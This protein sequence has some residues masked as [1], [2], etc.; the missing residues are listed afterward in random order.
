MRNKAVRTLTLIGFLVSSAFLAAGS[1]AAQ[2]AEGPSTQAFFRLIGTVG[3]KGF[4][5]AVIVDGTGAQTF[6]RLHDTAPDGS[7]IVAVE[8]DRIS[9][10]RPDGTRYE[11]FIIHDMMAS[12][13]SR[14]A[15]DTAS[16]ATGATDIR[17]TSPDMQRFAPRPG[18][19][20]P[21]AAAR[22]EAMERHRNKAGRN[23]GDQGAGT[24]QQNTAPQSGRNAV[25]QGAG[26]NQQNAATA[27]GADQTQRGPHPRGR[28]QPPGTPV[29]E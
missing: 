26:T 14:P 27:A 15:A 9:L 7:R 11:L 18:G 21:A 2:A 6:F 12:S 3:S 10:K 22:E 8:N 19:L 28:R 13:P 16:F 17:R 20:G 25:D 4:S 5:G 29:S 23:A 24:D 1:A